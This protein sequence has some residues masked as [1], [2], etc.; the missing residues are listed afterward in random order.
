MEHRGIALIPLTAAMNGSGMFMVHI[1]G[2]VLNGLRNQLLGTNGILS[3]FT[4]PTKKPQQGRLYKQE[5]DDL[6]WPIIKEKA[7]AVKWTLQGKLLKS[8]HQSSS[9]G[10]SQE[11]KSNENWCFDLFT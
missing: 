10:D 8:I 1:F 9:F 6:A 11:N 3:R 4:L 5:K 2:Q 7:D